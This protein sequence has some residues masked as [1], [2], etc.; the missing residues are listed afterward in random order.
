MLGLAIGVVA[1]G[2]FVASWRPT[3]TT[4]AGGAFFAAAGA[5]TS[6]RKDIAR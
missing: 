4:T 3:L 1:A 6:Q 2:Y 5:V